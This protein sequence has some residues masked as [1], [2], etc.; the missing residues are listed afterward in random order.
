M[1]ASANNLG[2]TS[3]STTPIC[4]FNGFASVY[5]EMLAVKENKQDGFS[6]CN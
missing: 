4:I 1:L 2:E 3:P 6:V 5:F